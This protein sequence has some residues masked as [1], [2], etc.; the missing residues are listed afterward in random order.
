MNKG[1]SRRTFLK[2]TGFASASAAYGHGR[3]FAGTTQS[4]SLPAPVL[5][6]RRV[7]KSKDIKTYSQ[8]ALNL[9]KWMMKNDPHYPTYHFAGPESW[10]ND[11]NGPICYKGKYHLFYQFDPQVDDGKGGWM[12]SK[13][14]WG[15]AVS[16]DLVYWRDWPVAVWPDTKYDIN[17]VYSGNT[18]VEAYVNGYAMTFVTYPHQ[19]NR[20][21]HVIRKNDVDIQSM[22]LWEMK[23]MWDR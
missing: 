14:T 15:H 4:Q 22:D 8:A 5:A 3:A 21:L 23:S 2:L 11:P 7:V 13:R 1:L 17:G 16:E 19:K 20:A 9:R 6:Y 12:R 18:F 10:I